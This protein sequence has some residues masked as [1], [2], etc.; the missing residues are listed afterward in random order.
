MP[1][2][3]TAVIAFFILANVIV[4]YRN[5]KLW[6]P[7]STDLSGYLAGVP[8]S[9]LQ[10]AAYLVLALTLPSIGFW[11]GGLWVETLMCL[12]CVGLV[13]VVVTKLVIHYAGLNPFTNSDL[14]LAHLASAG[15]TY[16][17][18]TVALL[19]HS[20]LTPSATFVCALLAPL[21]AAAFNLL[22]NGNPAL[23]EKTYTLFL[24][25]AILAAL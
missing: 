3:F 12:A 4:E 19:I 16:A 25:I 8:L 23:A 17:C 11:L 7:F 24:L 5:R 2:F 9:W 1:T 6:P 20:W 15:L 22:A 13:F 21:S 14:E 18:I 10:D